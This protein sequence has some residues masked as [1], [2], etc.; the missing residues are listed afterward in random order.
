MV[1]ER[2]LNSRA[3]QIEELSIVPEPSTQERYPNFEQADITLLEECCQKLAEREDMAVIADQLED[4][5]KKYPDEPAL[6]NNLSTALYLSDRKGR[7]NK[8]IDRLIES[9]P[10]YPIGKINWA[11]RQLDSGNVDPVL[12][13]L[14]SGWTLNRFCPDREE[15]YPQE[16]IGFCLLVIRLSLVLEEI[17]AADLFLGFAEEVA[18][19]FDC[20][21][22][23]LEQASKM[24]ALHTIQS[25]G[26]IE[27]MIRY[28]GKEKRAKKPRKSRKKKSCSSGE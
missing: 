3:P 2:A 13:L 24:I 26:F 8:L 25:E 16:V 27:E 1:I 10:N 23:E 12:T 14:K 5:S 22:P 21:S 4:L 28:L 6:L 7:A 11:H 19:A 9:Y 20:Y 17:E 18:E 15:F